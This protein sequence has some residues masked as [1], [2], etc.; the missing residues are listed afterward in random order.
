MKRIII[1]LCLIVM[2]IGVCRSDGWFYA[3]PAAGGGSGTWVYSNSHTPT[4]GD[5]TAT[6]TNTVH[7]GDYVVAPA[8]ATKITKLRW[9]VSDGASARNVRICVYPQYSGNSIGGGTGSTPGTSSGFMFV[10]TGTL[11]ISIVAETTYVILASVSDDLDGYYNAV[12]GLY[13]LDAYSGSACVD[14]ITPLEDAG[15]GHCVGAL[16]E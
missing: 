9:A 16:F 3:A 8:G 4:S 15:Y 12:D 14:S 10:D 5:S 7:V 6:I 2:P 1:I 13:S 11:D